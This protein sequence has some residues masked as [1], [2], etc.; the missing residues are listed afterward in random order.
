MIK[1]WRSC[2]FV[3]C[4]TIVLLEIVGLFVFDNT[5]HWKNRYLSYSKDAI[6][7]EEV[8]GKAFLEV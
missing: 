5:Y 8:N 4:A 2:L 7:N 6:V 3:I 1:K